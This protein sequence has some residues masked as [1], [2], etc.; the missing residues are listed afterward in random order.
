[1]DKL[2]SAYDAVMNYEGGI[3][4]TSTLAGILDIRKDYARGL[5]R[6]LAW[7]GVLKRADSAS[8]GTHYYI[9]R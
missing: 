4:R 8:H 9:I 6:S 7:L 3:I 5:V 2:Q 1:M